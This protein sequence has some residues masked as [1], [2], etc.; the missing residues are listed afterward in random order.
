MRTRVA[1]A[2]AAAGVIAVLMAASFSGAA[3][4]TSHSGWNWGSPQP[5]GNTLQAIEFAG[6]RGY[7]A[8]AFGTI[9]RTD[10]GGAS[11]SGIR[12][13]TTTSLSKVRAIDANTFLAGAGCMLL[14]SDDGGT[15]VRQLRFSP[16]RQCS[17]PL[18][19]FS[20]ASQQVGYLLRSDGSV[21]RT[22]DGGQ[23]FT[24]RT[25]L[26]LTGGAPTPPDDIWVT[27]PNHRV[28][29]TRADG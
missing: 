7:A 8:G 4:V 29:V 20:F 15:T 18:V 2:A 9:L 28:A 1:V 6:G 13:G 12:S 14:R 21:L 10:D 19:A 23:R 16:S 25:P 11:W 17:A 27:K 22:D 26:P 24:S 3:V 5:Q